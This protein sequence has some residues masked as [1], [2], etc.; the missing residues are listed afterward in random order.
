M[1][2]FSMRKIR[3]LVLTYNNKTITGH[4]ETQTWIYVFGLS[5]SDLYRCVIQSI[6]RMFC[7]ATS[8]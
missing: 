3:I 2:A 4:I 1:R 7:I 5:C 8:E 6:R